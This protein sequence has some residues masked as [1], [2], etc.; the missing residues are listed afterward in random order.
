MRWAIPEAS[1]RTIETRDEGFDIDTGSDSSSVVLHVPHA[2]TTIPLWVRSQI[3]LEDEVLA[4][5]LELMT[6]AQTDLIAKGFAESF[7]ALRAGE[8]PQYTDVVNEARGS[9][10]ER[11]H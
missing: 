3:L 9:V 10:V 4:R 6:D 11:A 1:D 5:E 8:V 7:K 2:A